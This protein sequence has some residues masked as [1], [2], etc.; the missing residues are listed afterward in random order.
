VPYSLNMMLQISSS[1]FGM[2]TKAVPALFKAHNH[3]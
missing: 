3:N 1:K 2:L